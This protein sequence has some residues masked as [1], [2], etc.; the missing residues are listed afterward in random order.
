M[1]ISDKLAKIQKRAAALNEKTDAFNATIEHIEKGLAGCGVE[2]WWIADQNGCQLNIE[3]SSDGQEKQRRFSVLGY[4][5]VGGE[6]C[7]AVR[8][9]FEVCH[10]HDYSGDPIW[11]DDGEP[12]EPTPLRRASRALRI[13]AAPQLEQFLD[14]LYEAIGEME[15]KV[16]EAN[17]I[18]AEDKLVGS[19]TAGL[20]AKRVREDSRKGRKS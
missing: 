8:P 15:A 3:R 1:A 5:K 12:G 16:G 11:R 13:E 6:W 18:I 19:E 10:E 2:F 4:T 9:H 14:A 17:Q 7:L 20:V